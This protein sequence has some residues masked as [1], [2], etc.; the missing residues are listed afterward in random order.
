MTTL[1]AIRLL[2]DQAGWYVGDKRALEVLETYRASAL[3]ND[4]YRADHLKAIEACMW[5]HDDKT[6]GIPLGGRL[7]SD[8]VTAL[9]K[10]RDDLRG[11]L[12]D[13][14]QSIAQLEGMLRQAKEDLN[15]ARYLARHARQTLDDLHIQIDE[16]GVTGQTDGSIQAK[17]NA[18]CHERDTLKAKL[19]A[20]AQTRDDAMNA[21]HIVHASLRAELKRQHD[22]NPLNRNT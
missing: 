16:N 10:Q 20:L 22:E 19:A 17:I 7:T 9:R 3:E 15:T 12:V 14:D 1:E 5:M 18:V 8:G 4:I 2:R 11:Q 21:A 6:L 13:R